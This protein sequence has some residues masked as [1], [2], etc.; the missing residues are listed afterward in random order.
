MNTYSFK[1]VIFDLDGVVTKTASVHSQSW[2]AAFDEYLRLREE[3]D[4]EAFGEFTQQ[5]YLTYVDGKPRY[6]GVKSFLQSR[7]IN[8]EWGSPEDSPERETVCGLGNT[9]NSKFRQVLK[10]KGV[11]IYTSTIELIKELKTKGIKIGVASSS[12]NCRYIMESAGIEDLFATRVDGEVSAELKLNGKP[13]GDI[14]VMAASNLGVIPAQAVVVEDAASGVEAGR[15]GGFGLVIGLARHNNQEELISHYTDVVV[16][17]LSHINPDWIERWFNKKP[18]YLFDAWD[19]NIKIQD[20]LVDLTGNGK[21]IINPGYT[22]GAKG[23]FSSGKKLVFFLDY[24]GTLTPIVERPDLAVLSQDMKDVLKAIV[25]KYTTAVVSGRAR[26]DVEAL[27]GIEGLFYAGSHGLDIRGKSFSMIQPEAEKAMPL[28]LEIAE[29]LSKELS[30]IKGI[31]IE[32]KKFSVAVHYRLVEEKLVPKIE[33]IVE[34]YLPADNSLHLM[35]GKKV[36]EIMSAIDWNKGRA[37]RWI[38]RALNISWDE[39]V[40]IYIGD[41]TT[42]EDAFR[43]VRAR[44][45]GILVSEQDK[46]SAADFRLSNPEE[47][48]RLFE[49]LL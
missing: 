9:K 3:R 14:F 27:V 4:G 1:A 45:V 48:K 20:S 41:D 49:K 37:I 29:G 33:N 30:D 16:D 24:D 34:K 17:D 43:S 15:N 12:K 23:V 44:G 26:A 42:D 19:E 7:R 31:L 35:R 40:V 18:V 25:G 47:V 5:D 38:M 28:I 2:K 22:R 32:N 6:Q 11:E 36:F 10:E 13:E 39:A 8:I 46:A 21:V